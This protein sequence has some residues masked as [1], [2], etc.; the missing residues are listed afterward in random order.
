MAEKKTKK[1]RRSHSR[2]CLK[3]SYVVGF[4][5]LIFV[6]VAIATTAAMIMMIAIGNRGAFNPSSSVTVNV[7]LYFPSV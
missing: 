4:F 3:N 6:T 5:R 1:K 2:S 7:T